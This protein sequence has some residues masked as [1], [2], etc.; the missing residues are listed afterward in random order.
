MADP[1]A[2]NACTGNSSQSE[3]WYA[4]M[5]CVQ[6]LGSTPIAGGCLTG[7]AST[8]STYCQTQCW[9]IG[10]AAPGCFSC[11]GVC[12]VEGGAPCVHP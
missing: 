11:S 12:A 9:G 10:T 2:Q 1:A 8:P 5:T 7:G 4:G 6:A 3:Q